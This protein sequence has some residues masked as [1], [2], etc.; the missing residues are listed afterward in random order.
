MDIFS[1]WMKSLFITPICVFLLAAVSANAAI[2]AVSFG[3][4]GTADA[5]L[6]AP[7]D[8]TVGR[9]VGLEP[10]YRAL[11]SSDAGFKFVR[12]IVSSDVC[13]YWFRAD[14]NPA[15]LTNTEE[16]S[17]VYW[18]EGGATCIFLDGAEDGENNY[19]LLHSQELDKIVGVLQYALNGNNDM[20]DPARLMAYAVNPEGMTFAQGVAAIQAIP[21]PSAMVLGT[22]AMVGGLMGRRRKKDE[23]YSA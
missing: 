2:T 23:V 12:H 17:T 1:P 21:E 16:W 14:G 15:A 5:Q 6:I 8:T 19:V 9:N 7:L 22:L 4:E 13:Y 3:A 10:D 18:Y 11:T 20:N